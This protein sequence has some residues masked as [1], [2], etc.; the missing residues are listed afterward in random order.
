MLLGYAA[1][2]SRRTFPVTSWQEVSQAYLG[3]IDA[4]HKLGIRSIPPCEILNVLGK[5]AYW[6]CPYTGCVWHGRPGTIKPGTA[7]IYR[8]L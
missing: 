6:V 4:A 7:P 3:M 1:R 5:V 2:V 8:P